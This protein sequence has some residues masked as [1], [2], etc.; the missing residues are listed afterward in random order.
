MSNGQRGRLVLQEVPPGD[1]EKRIV[2]LL[3]KFAKSVSPEDLIAKVRNTPYALSNDIPAEKALIL[4]EALQKL[5][6]TAAFVPHAPVQPPVEEITAIERAPRFTF[7][8]PPL[9]KEEPPAVLP[10][11]RKSG[12]RRLAMTLV[13]ILFLLSMGYLAWQLWPL[14]GNTIRELGS[15]LKQLF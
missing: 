2:T 9:A 14:V 5:G 7:D 10:E 1:V 3:S 13:T 12:T 11:P 4:L 15:Y 8:S 6:A